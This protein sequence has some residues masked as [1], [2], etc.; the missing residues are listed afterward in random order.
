MCALAMIL[1]RLSES[2]PVGQPR[3]GLRALRI[4]SARSS[5]MPQKKKSGRRGA[6][7]RKTAGSPATGRSG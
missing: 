1:S 3:F 6:R 7:A 2:Y 4:A 5:I